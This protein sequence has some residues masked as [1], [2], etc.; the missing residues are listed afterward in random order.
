MASSNNN[1]NN[2]NYQL[3]T[4]VGED[5]VVI[6]E[7]QFTNMVLFVKEVNDEDK[8]QIKEGKLFFNVP[9]VGM[10]TLQV[11]LNKDLPW[12]SLED[13]QVPSEEDYLSED[14][15]Q[16]MESYDLNTASEQELDERD[17]I[18]YDAVAATN[19]LLSAIYSYYKSKGY[20]VD[21]WHYEPQPQ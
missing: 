7:S 11:T 5:S 21:I 1:N 14:Q 2:N 4:F 13:C 8:Q 10:V 17:A 15:K 3:Q 19:P 12:V 20:I 18:L 6:L 9:S 16:R